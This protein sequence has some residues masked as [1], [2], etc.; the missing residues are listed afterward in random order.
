MPIAGY[1]NNCAVITVFA[2]SGTLLHVEFLLCRLLF[3]LYNRLR[4]HNFGHRDIIFRTY[5]ES[6]PRK[7]KNKRFWD[8]ILVLMSFGAVFS[9]KAIGA[10]KLQYRG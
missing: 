3:T 5:V 6:D 9:K 1:N 7:I 8:T 4:S 10:Q 2:S